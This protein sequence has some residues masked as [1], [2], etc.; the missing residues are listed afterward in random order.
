[1][2]LAI[3][4]RVVENPTYRDRRDALSQ[5]WAITFARHMPEAVLV[6]VPNCLANV[7]AWLGAVQPR[8][9][10]LSGGNDWGTAP[11]RDATETALFD[12]AQQR[13]IPL[14]GVCRGLQVIHKLTGGEIEPSIA[15]A[16]GTSHTA[17]QHGIHLAAGPF[18]DIA[19]QD[20]ICVNSYHDQ[21]VLLSSG[22]SADLEVFAT[23]G[24]GVEGFVHRSR[25]VL[26]IQWHPER[27]GSPS[28][29]DFAIIR[30]LFSQ[31]AFWL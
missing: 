1:V 11:D 27:D 16:T 9:I 20:E 18:R 8:G 26:A 12:F 29:F 25:P 21:G 15:A 30:K 31:G 2:I 6:P 3:S 10:I 14:L 28:D 17:V 7:A 24:D 19:R 22:L 23:A 13:D 5:D 4:Q